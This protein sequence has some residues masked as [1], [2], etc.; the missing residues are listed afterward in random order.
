MGIPEIFLEVSMDHLQLHRRQET[1]ELQATGKVLEMECQRCLLLHLP[2]RK[3]VLFRPKNLRLFHAKLVDSRMSC[4]ARKRREKK[5]FQMA[6][7]WRM[8]G[9]RQGRPI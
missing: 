9:E 5:E 2:L 8:E 6:R 1:M 4:W 7:R 3:H